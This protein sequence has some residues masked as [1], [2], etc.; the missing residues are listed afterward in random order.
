MPQQIGIYSS[1]S[2][3]SG[4]LLPFTRITSLSG[5]LNIKTKSDEQWGGGYP[6]VYT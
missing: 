1:G 2:R 4:S 5:K 6:D 3:D